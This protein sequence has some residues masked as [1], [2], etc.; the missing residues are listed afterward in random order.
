M[1]LDIWKPQG[2]G[3]RQV[4]FSDEE[5]EPLHRYR[6]EV[7]LGGGS[8]PM[9][10]F[11]HNPSTAD[12]KVDDP[13]LKSMI[14]IARAR[15]ASRLVVINPAS[16][17]TPKPVELRRHFAGG[18]PIVGPDNAAAI[19][20]ALIGLADHGGMLVLG[21]GVLDGPR[22]FRAAMEAAITAVIAMPERRLGVPAYCLGR[23]ADGSPKHPLYVAA[24][25]PLV[26]W[27]ARH[28]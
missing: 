22:A 17:R 21:W 9:G 23:N 7:E 12:H 2:A 19:R 13:S 3:L 25:T 28:G 24:S 11:L 5:P 10:F 20:A 16:Y 27:E 15:D 26:R 14:R 1:R 18:S 6:L 8:V 4:W